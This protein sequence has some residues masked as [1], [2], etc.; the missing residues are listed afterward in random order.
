MMLLCPTVARGAEAPAETGS[1]VVEAEDPALAAPAS[2]VQPAPSAIPV[3]ATYNDRLLIES[4]DKRFTL[5][6]IIIL[7]SLFSLPWNPSGSPAYE[8]LG[9]SFRRGALGFDSRL[10]TNVRTFFLAN[11]ANGT[12]NLWDFFTDLDYFD[13]RAVLRVGRFR[14]WLGRQRLLAGDR[15]QMIQLP[16]AMT[17]LLEFGDGRDLG[18][19]IFGLLA[20]KTIEYDLGMWN[21][22]QKYSNDPVNGFLPSTNLRSRG[23]VDFEFGSRLVF[24]PFGYLPA[25]DES[26]LAFSEKP[27]LSI[28]AAAMFAKRHDVRAPDRMT[29][30]SFFDD[31]LLKVGFEFDFRWRGFSLEAEAFARKAWMLSST[32]ATGKA[33][34]E[35]LNQSAV[36][37]SAY[38]QGGYFVSPR[39][40][41]VTARVDYV[42]VEPKIPG[43]IL[44]P[45]LG[46]NWFI[47]SYNVLFQVMYRAN[48]GVGFRDSEEHKKDYYFW[49]SLRPAERTDMY[50]GDR[51]MSMISHDLFLMLQTSL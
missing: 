38:A 44:R 32:D 24:H 31:R 51:K 14:P 34:F 19:G 1:P 6:P 10:F 18:A 4:E 7:Q 33:M 9:F 42:D 2:V 47:H 12:L 21:G 16:V 43:Y 5:Q 26:D 35:K 22:E 11:I 25:I 46:L 48:V 3:H 28:G 37:K 41:E 49:S 20:D 39:Q 30:P 27:K 17:D 15:Y 50:L 8:G 29:T 36:G 13:G 23:N 40:V 45:A